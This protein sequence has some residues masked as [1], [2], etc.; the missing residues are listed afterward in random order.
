[1]SESLAAPVNEVN[2]HNCFG[3]GTLNACGLGLTMYPN[4]DGN[5][6]WAPFAPAA[7]F[8][9]YPGMIHGGIVCTVLDEV[10]A[11][12]LYREE[13]WAVTGSL[14]VRYR[15]PLAV[16]ET[17]RAI[18]TIERNR[19]RVI[20]TRGEIRRE[21]DGALLAEATATFVRVPADQAEAWRERYL[22]AETGAG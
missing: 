19:G 14:Q 1:M 6:V 5:G 8:E 7:R 13:I 20:E 18:G 12:S 9:G 4:A 15:R 16:G 17:L 2:D 10:M 3:C 21:T 22:G 11:W